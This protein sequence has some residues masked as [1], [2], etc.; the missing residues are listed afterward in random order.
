MSK[1]NKQR[2]VVNSVAK[3]SKDGI[4]TP[5]ELQVLRAEDY[6]KRTDSAN[7]QIEN[8]LKSHNL[9]IRVKLNYGFNAITPV[10]ELVDMKAVEQVTREA[11]AQA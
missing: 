10:I 4:L 6:K 3:K 5:E 8:V 9:G 7:A 1:A 11:P 2:R